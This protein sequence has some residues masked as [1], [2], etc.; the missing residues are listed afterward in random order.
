MNPSCSVQTPH[1]ALVVSQSQA[2]PPAPQIND[3]APPLCATHG[4]TSFLPGCRLPALQN[5]SPAP[6]TQTFLNICL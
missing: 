1:G 3:L 6:S 5:P 2:G 4:N